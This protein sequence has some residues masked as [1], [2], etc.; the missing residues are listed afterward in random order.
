MTEANLK[1][2]FIGESQANN[3]YTIFAEKAK[4]L[5]LIEKKSN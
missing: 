3:K 4:T 1:N 5:W 2:A